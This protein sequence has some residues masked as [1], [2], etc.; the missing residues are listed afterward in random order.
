MKERP[1][2]S[3]RNTMNQRFGYNI[4]SMGGDLIQAKSEKGNK[5]ARIWITCYYKE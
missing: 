4:R 1:D 2:D 5:R 3:A